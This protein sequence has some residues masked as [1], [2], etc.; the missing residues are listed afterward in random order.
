MNKSS[1]RIII[2]AVVA[3]VFVGA[4]AALILTGRLGGGILD[5]RRCD[6]DLI[7]TISTANT[8]HGHV[9]I[10]SEQ[11]STDPDI[12][13]RDLT[14]STCVLRIYPSQTITIREFDLERQL[15]INSIEN[16]QVNFRIDNRN[17]TANIGEEYL[18]PRAPQCLDCDD[19]VHRL[20]FTND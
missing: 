3:L 20:T 15:I 12:N 14:N 19:L 7:S 1:T 5:N 11:M 10:H 18:L 6:P 9:T 16:D 17:H 2:T 8:H 13:P 4:L